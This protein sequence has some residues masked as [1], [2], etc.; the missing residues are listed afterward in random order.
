MKIPC[1]LTALLATAVSAQAANILSPSDSIIAIGEFGSLSNYPGGEPPSA[2][3]DADP[4]TKYLNFSKENSGFIVTPGPSTV[5]SVVFTSANDADERDPTTFSIWGTNDA[6]S[7]LDNS[8]GNSEAWT[9]ILTSSATNI[10]TTRLTAGASSNL[11]S[12]VSYSSYRVAFDTLRDSVAANSMQIGGVQFFNGANGTGTSI[13]GAGNSIIGI[14]LDSTS[15]SGFP[16]A[17]APGSAIDGVLGSKYL[18]FGGS[19]T[20]FIVTPAMGASVVDG[21]VIT[22]GNDAPDRDPLEYALYG[23]NDSISSVENSD[24]SQENWVLI[25]GGILVPPAGRGEDYGDSISGNLAEY[26]SYRFDVVATNG[27]GLLQF[28]EIQFTGKIPEPSTGLLAIL[29]LLPILRRRR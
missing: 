10:P 17:E 21:F 19:N 27:G 3:L 20:G 13:L 23:T 16:G 29:G 26:S 11:A 4:N 12:G 2:V 14:D 24:G 7:S 9:P 15:T 6:I 22:T 28:D 8:L 1:T 18:N 5:E 25:K